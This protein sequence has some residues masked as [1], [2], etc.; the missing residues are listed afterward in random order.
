MPTICDPLPIPSSREPH[1]ILAPLNLGL[2]AIAILGTRCGA[3]INDGGEL[4]WFVEPG[5]AEG[6]NVPSTRL[7]TSSRN[8]VIIPPHRVTTGPAAHWRVCPG[9]HRWLTDTPALR[10]ALE[11]ASRQ[12]ADALIPSS[13]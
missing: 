13:R 12:L 2:P 3:A 1:L 5:S 7:L 8:Q 10:A 11:D 6:W 4:I 9:E